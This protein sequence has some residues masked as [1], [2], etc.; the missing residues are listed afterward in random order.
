LLSLF[1]RSRETTYKPNREEIKMNKEEL[2]YFL[3]EIAKEDLVN[4]A[5]VYDHP[6][7]VA[8]RAL[9]QCFDD[10][11]H[12]SKVVRGD[13]MGHSKRTK[14]LVGLSYNPSW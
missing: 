9:N 7:S 5:D 3:E 11:T 1:E 2:V 8:I 12:L 4:G 6:C 14:T 10:V 13:L